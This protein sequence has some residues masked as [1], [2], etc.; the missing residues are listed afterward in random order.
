MGN[1]SSYLN[2]F[3]DLKP[4]D[5]QKAFLLQ[6][7]IFLLITSLLIVKPTVSSLFLSELS[8]EA[9]P[10]A[11]LLTA[12]FAVVFSYFY[13]RILW[14]YTLIKIIIW[15]LFSCAALLILF[16]IQL[17]LRPSSAFWL[18]LPYLFV[19]IFGLLTTSQFWILAN[20]IF[21]VR[22]AKRLFGFIGAGAIA[23]GIAG[24]YLAS[25]LSRFIPSQDLL[26]VAALMLL[27]CVPI[28]GYLWKHHVYWRKK[29]RPERT[30]HPIPPLKM[31]RRN[32]LLSFLTL[33][34]GVS[35]LVAKM[36]DY[37]YSHFAA[38]K[39]SDPEA[40]TAFFGFWFS[41]LSIVS[42]GIQLLLTKRILRRFG[43]GK[44]LAFMPI[45]IFLGSLLLLVVPELWVVV[46]IK[47]VEGSL[48]QSL[49]KA[50]TELVVL[51]VPIEVKKHTKPFIDI[52]VDSI[53]TG[54]A[55]AILIFLINGLNVPSLYIS[56]INLALV[57][58][59][60]FLIRRMFRAY[61][62]TFRE[63]LVSEHPR[64]ARQEPTPIDA[65]EESAYG[66]VERVLESGSESQVLFMLERILEHPDEHYLP[67]VRK[68]LS[69][70]SPHVRALAIRVLYYLKS[71]DLRQT[72][73]AM[74]N[75]PSDEVVIEALR[76]LIHRDHDLHREEIVQYEAHSSHR[77]IHA[78]TLLAVA[79]EVH[80]EPRLKEILHLGKRVDQLLANLPE[81]ELDDK[82][83][84]DLIAVLEAIGHTHLQTH[85]GVVQSYLGHP[86]QEVVTAALDA[87][88]QIQ[89]PVFLEAIVRSL[90]DKKIRPKSILALRTSGEEVIPKLTD[91]AEQ[92][93]VPLEAAMFI[94]DA[95]KDIG[96][97]KAVQAL[98]RLINTTEYSVS[99][100]A[101]QALKEL[102]DNRPELKIP[103]EEVARSILD[104]CS[105]YQQMLGFLHAQLQLHQEGDA[106][107]S[108]RIDEARRGLIHLL[109]HRVDGQL[110]RIFQLIGIHYHDKEV[111]PILTII[112]KGSDQERINA[113]EF[114]ENILDAHLRPVVLPIVDLA[115][116]GK[117]LSEDFLRSLN[118]PDFTEAQCFETL[119]RRHDLRIKHAVLYL[120][121]QLG[122]RAYDPLVE[123][124]TQS[125][126][127]TVRSQAEAVLKNLRSG[128]NA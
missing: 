45:G 67:V 5:I 97:Q 102:K 52:V 11:Y 40:L 70:S 125:P 81:G 88:A 56:Y 91:M 39:I 23:G 112:R 109:E 29:V 65:S 85:Y 48:K 30:A 41:T 110:D 96:T 28:S 78:L 90:P 120:I 63:L 111:D 14:K 93:A 38:E 113:I 73:A 71:G 34:V 51:P 8:S 35:V 1:A 126:F 75:D 100:R 80:T 127:Q 64:A 121:E 26:L 33:S 17:N 117:S 118:L 54:L 72:M 84:L 104:E 101:L 25:F 12:V 10:T 128:E 49:N 68:R 86:D 6:V 108:G 60:L 82:E 62:K 98:V 15:T 66:V 58:I 32:P 2:R 124:L 79:R 116:S 19:A 50:A 77:N 69:D 31:I 59:W 27:A 83:R 94:P 24:G 95:L 122:N 22:E 107:R 74:L 43:L 13:D 16:C 20:M 123:R 42:L 47:I 55:G 7:F 37:Q 105:I 21:N 114:I 61:L 9:L 103:R 99:V 87:A 57:G 92:N 3:F 115:S 44:S 18:Y 106:E 53:A 119:T 4:E 46:L 36:V 89:E 76:Y